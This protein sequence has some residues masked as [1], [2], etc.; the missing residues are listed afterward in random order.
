L[1]EAKYGEKPPPTEDFPAPPNL[2]AFAGDYESHSFWARLEARDGRLRGDISG[3][4]TVFTPGGG[5]NFAAHSRLEDATPAAFKQDGSGSVCGFTMGLQQFQRV[6]AQA[7]PLPAAWRAF[8]GGYGPDFIPVIVSERH[9]HLYAMTENMVDY[10][11]T[12]L[13]RHACALPPG[14]YAGEQVVFLDQADGR[15]RA[16][17]FAN[18]WLPRRNDS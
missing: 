11:L 12:P 13:N 1:L 8:C 9:G 14:M 18:M 3:Q 5:L 10:R 17:D 16:I 4:P 7:P 6:P 2:A 15:P